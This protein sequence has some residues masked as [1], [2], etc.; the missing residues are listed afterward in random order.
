LTSNSSESILQGATM[1]RLSYVVTSAIVFVAASWASAADPGYTVTTIAGNGKAADNG[2]EGKALEIN[3]G[4]PF[5][6]EIGPDGALYIAEVENHRVRRLDLQKGMLST[7]AGSGKKG[8]EAD[9][10]I[11]ARETAANEPYEIRFDPAGNLLVVEMQNHVVRRVYRSTNVIATI[12]GSGQP[13]FSGDGGHPISATLRQ[14]H[15]IAIDGDKHLYI[16]DIGNHRIR[17]VDLQSSKIE[18]IAGNGQAQLPM[19]DQPALGQPL[20][21]PRALA[22]SGQTLWIALREGNL[23]CKLDLTTGKIHAVAGS[24]AKGF[25][26]GEKAKPLTAT[27]N[28]PK[29]IALDAKGRVYIADTENHAIRRYDPATQSVETLAGGGPTARGFGG[30]DGPGLQAKFD[31]PHGVAVGTDGAVYVGDSNNHRVRMLKSPDK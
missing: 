8:Y 2:A 30:D 26:D 1:L 3:I 15:S 19:W 9:G 18:T 13:G 27:F 31:R 21:G 14:P 5:G 6:L 16:A 25:S 4:Q 23:L 12:A 17:R 20:K 22:I 24:G 10:L 28:G 29:G 11:K 7:I